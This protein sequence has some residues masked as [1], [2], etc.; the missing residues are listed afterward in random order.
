MVTMTVTHKL[1]RSQAARRELILAEARRVVSD[2]G[3]DALSMKELAVA[4]NVPRATLYRLYTS[5]EHLISDMALEWGYSLVERLQ[6]NQPAGSTIG[7]KI[8]GVLASV[9]REAEDNPR[10]IQL[11]LT[12]LL[13]ADP[14]V[15]KM[16]SDIELLLPALLGSVLTDAELLQLRQ[17]IKAINRILLSCLLLLGSGRESFG[18]SLSCLVFTTQKLFGHDLWKQASH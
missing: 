9:L 4:C 11:T 12:S 16:Q 2:H 18:E 5:K 1:N 7:E 6:Q 14:T 8:T 17:E 13:S 15:V 10:L 3:E